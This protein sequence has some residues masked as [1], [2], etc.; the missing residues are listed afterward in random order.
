MVECAK[1][2]KKGQRLCIIVN[3]V[4]FFFVLLE[5]S[6]LA[7]SR[8]LIVSSPCRTVPPDGYI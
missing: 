3:K 8:D 7:E 6:R 4:L 1:F 5:R 2:K